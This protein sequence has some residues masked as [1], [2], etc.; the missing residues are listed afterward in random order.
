MRHLHT[1]G[2]CVV[3][4]ACAPMTAGNAVHSDGDVAANAT[5][6]LKARCATGDPCVFKGGELH[7]DIE[8][9]NRTAGTVGFPLAFVQA[10][11]PSIRLT[12]RRGGEG[13][14]L[15]TN[16]A[17]DD[18]RER[19]TPIPPGGSVT[20]RWLIHASELETFDRR[21]LDVVAEIALAPQSAARKTLF[22]ATTELRIRGAAH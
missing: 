11:G 8:I 16:L 7:I 22:L 4:S 12:D 18:L 20:L 1:V 10:T 14:Q 9:A 15:R 6:T 3:L 13:L 17:P 5:V 19:F 21:P 2:L